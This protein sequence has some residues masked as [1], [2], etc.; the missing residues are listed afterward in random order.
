MS[1]FVRREEDR[2]RDDEE[3]IKDDFYKYKDEFDHDMKKIYD[4]E[5]DEPMSDFDNI[6]QYLHHFRWFIN[7]FL[8]GI[9]WF[10]FAALSNDYNL[11]WN[12]K[13]NHFW[14]GGNV[15]LFVN[16]IYGFIQSFLST[17]IVMEIP[18]WLKEAKSIRMAS[19]NAAFWYNIF[20]FAFFWRVRSIWVKTEEVSAN[21]I[22]TF[23][24]CGYNLL[25]HGP[26]FIINLGIMMTEVKFEILQLLNDALDQ[27][28]DYSLGLV[29]IYMFYRNVFFILNPLNWFDLIY[30]VIYGYGPQ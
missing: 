24:F 8:L 22:F 13:W 21:D 11:L 26:I 7:F 15:F 27:D 9:P 25:I 3:I 29:H 1:D 12:L 30:Y 20:Y 17:L 4:E 19:F 6:W 2:I 23:L 18:T 28:Q 5:E 16:T 10:F 14:A